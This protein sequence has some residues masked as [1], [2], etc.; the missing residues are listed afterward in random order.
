MDVSAAAPANRAGGRPMPVVARLLVAVSALLAGLAGGACGVAEAQLLP[1]NATTRGTPGGDPARGEVALRSYGCG[2]CHA[3][4]GVAGAH[5]RLAPPLDGWAGRQI[6]AGTLPNTPE[7][8]VLWIRD[9]QAYKPG[10]NMPDVGVSTEDARDMAAY[11]YT[12]R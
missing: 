12:L 10:T 9:P 5:G 7:Q 6:I 1:V 3:I 11:L 8:L 2:A 4:P